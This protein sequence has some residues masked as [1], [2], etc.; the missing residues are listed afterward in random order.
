MSISD[1]I[2]IRKIRTKIGVVIVAELQNAEKLLDEYSKSELQNLMTEYLVH[3]ELEGVFE[4]SRNNDGAPYIKSDKF[5]EISISHSSNFF[6][7]YL[8]SEAVG[9]DIEADRL[10]KQAGKSYF[11]NDNENQDWSNAELLAIWSGKESLYK[12]LKGQINDLRLDATTEEISDKVVLEYN[13]ER[14]SFDLFQNGEY[15]L[16]YG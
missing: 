9:V 2:L 12:K 1:N 15:T 16:V 5:S 10:I 4:I 11:I 7:V 13:G 6:C 3:D 8:A 14:F